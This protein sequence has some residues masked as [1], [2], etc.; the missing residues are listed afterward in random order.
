[1]AKHPK[2]RDADM[3]LPPE[4]RGRKKRSTPR[5]SRRKS[6][7]HDHATTPRAKRRARDGSRK[8]GER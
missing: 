3:S 4:K 5:M 1:M 7:Q 6:A 8:M 2:R